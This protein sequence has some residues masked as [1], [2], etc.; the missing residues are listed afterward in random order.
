MV[1]LTKQKIIF[2]VGPTASGKSAWALEQVKRTGGSIVNIDSVQ[3]YQGLLIGS[4]AP[5]DEEKFQAKHYLYSY[6]KAPQEMTAGRYLTDF[7]NLLK[8]D[9]EFPLYV[10]GGTGFYIQALE[11]GMFDVEPIAEIHREAIENELAEGGSEKLFAEL[12]LKDPQ[13][14]IHNN[15]HFRLVRAIEIL[16]HTKK[17]PSQMKADQIENKNALK[18]PYIKVGFNFEKEIFARRVVARTKK[19]VS[20]GII[21]ETEVALRNGYESWAPLAS[22]GYK[23]TVEFLKQAHSQEWLR[24]AIE[25]STMKLIKK[26]KTWFRRDDAILWSDHSPDTLGTL[27]Q[28][29]NSFLM[30]D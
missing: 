4:A 16:R 12:K 28:N 27:K 8:T 15:D 23:E 22:V 11:K 24:L 30:R 19:I 5:T 17:I 25:Q 18:I 14:K 10:V 13:S 20:G 29:L 1:A 26:Q 21:E 6:V 7:Y 2:V 9:I 3:F